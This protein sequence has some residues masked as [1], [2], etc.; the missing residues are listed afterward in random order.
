MNEK[1][2]SDF[3]NEIEKKNKVQLDILFV[4]IMKSKFK[5]KKFV[6]KHCEETILS[7]QKYAGNIINNQS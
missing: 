1:I 4:D 6:K 3:K 7:I 2:A 5:L